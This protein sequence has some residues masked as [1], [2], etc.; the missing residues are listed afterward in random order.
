MTDSTPSAEQA[1]LLA[2]GPFPD[3]PFTPKSFVHPNGL[4]QSYLDEGQGEVVLML[5]GNP[6]WSYYWRKLVLALRVLDRVAFCIE[7]NDAPLDW[8]WLLHVKNKA[9]AVELLPWVRWI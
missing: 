5:H 7:R 8:H 4:T 1:R 3:Y 6:S 2:K 9:P